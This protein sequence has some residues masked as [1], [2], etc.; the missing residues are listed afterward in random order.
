MLLHKSR[1]TTP[2]IPS[3]ND[4]LIN[5]TASAQPYLEEFEQLVMRSKHKSMARLTYNFAMLMLLQLIII[6]MMQSSR[7]EVIW[8]MSQ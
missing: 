6:G 1:A 3:D 2:T 4:W 7:P 5:A 8:L